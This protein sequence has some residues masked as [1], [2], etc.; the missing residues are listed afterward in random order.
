MV[1]LYSCSPI[2][3]LTIWGLACIADNFCKGA[4]YWIY[5]IL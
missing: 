4:A 5:L 2:T 1:V 3:I